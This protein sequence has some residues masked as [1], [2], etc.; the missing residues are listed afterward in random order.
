[1]QERVKRQVRRR[2]GNRCEYCGLRQE[3][4]RF[5]SFHLEHV[6][7]QAHGGSD[8]LDNLALACHQCNL[9]KGTNLSGL[10]P[11][12]NRLVRLFHPRKDRWQDHFTREGIR[13]AGRTAIGRTTAWVLQMNSEERLDLRRLLLALGELD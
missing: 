8:A 3:Q 4:D 11:D 2:A 5:H 7:A 6:I 10:D 12:T 13:I 1:M 9:H